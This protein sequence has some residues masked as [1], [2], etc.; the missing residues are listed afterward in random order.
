M[1]MYFGSS[2]I[3]L[4]SINRLMPLIHYSIK[5][6]TICYSGFLFKKGVGVEY[7]LPLNCTF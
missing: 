6:K 4:W 5:Q 2:N 7:G 3:C 1:V